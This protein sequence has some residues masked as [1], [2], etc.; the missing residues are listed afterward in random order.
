MNL[1][2]RFAVSFILIALVSIAAV[3]IFAR[4]ST[5]RE[6]N[7][8]MFRGGMA[9][10]NG[11]VSTLEKYYQTHGS[12]N[13]VSGQLAAAAENT[14]HMTGMSGRDGQGIMQQDLLLADE[15]S[16]ILYDS[17]GSRA[18]ASLTAAEKT[19]AIVLR[20]TKQQAVGYLYI[21]G[22]MPFQPGA[23]RELVDRL[24]KAAL[25]AGLIAG[26]FSLLI[27]GVLG[28]LILRPV[29][30]LTD[31][32]NRIAS[33]DLAERVPVTGNDEL[34]VLGKAFNT[35]A[36]SL[37]TAQTNRKA[38]TADIAHELRTPLAIQRAI[39]EAITDGVYPLDLQQIQLVAQQNQ[40]LT[41]LVEDLRTL[42]LADA[43]ELR[44]ELTPVDL[45]ALFNRLVKEFEPAAAEREIRLRISTTDEPAGWLVRADSFRLGQVIN[46]LLSNAIRYSP[47]G[48]EVTGQLSRAGGRIILSVSDSGSG[49]PV[50]EEE[51]IFERFFR[52]DASRSRNDGGSGLG[53]AIAR[54]LARAH[55]GDLTA[56]NR[57]DGGACFILS[58]PAD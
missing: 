53:L 44:L 42:A 2:L 14:S 40:S 23:D 57:P 6:I 9:G 11:V 30:R 50:G 8:Y 21:A 36:Q 5:A 51:N 19:G 45:K 56:E 31:A 1:R 10:V 47:S 7:T 35:M 48:G 54:Q 26:G 28:Y 15:N 13:G 32:A 3:V 4:V 16:V 27:A 25:N 12:W 17:R 43:G 41:R 20:G 34:A 22:G 38:M 29:R 39:L 37:E 58:L 55:G 24:D 18:G 52:G 46:N 49:I 33:G